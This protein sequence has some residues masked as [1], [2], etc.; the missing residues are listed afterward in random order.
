MR[1]ILANVAFGWLANPWSNWWGIECGGISVC[2]IV[3]LQ[4][5]RWDSWLAHRITGWS[6]NRGTS[7]VAACLVMRVATAKNPMALLV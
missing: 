7:L 1:G 2:P 4:L 3:M 5:I 6:S